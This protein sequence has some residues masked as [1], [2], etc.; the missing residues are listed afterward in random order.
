MNCQFCDP[1]VRSKETFYENQTNIALVNIKPA[2]EGH[3]LL[4]PKRHV[5]H[6]TE[7]A[8][9]EISGMF[10]SVKKIYKY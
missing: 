1:E 5:Q 3:V 9:K 7:L 2:V 8:E 6:F 4:I 10:S